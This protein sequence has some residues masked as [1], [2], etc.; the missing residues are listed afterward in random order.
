[1]VERRT[2]EREGPG[3][4]PHDCRVVSLSKIKALQSTGKYPGSSGSVPT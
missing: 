2:L 3:F 1:M 4:E